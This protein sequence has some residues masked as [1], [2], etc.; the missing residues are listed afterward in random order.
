[1]LSLILFF[2]LFSPSLKAE[3]PNF[4]IIFTDDQGYEDIGCFGSPKIKTPHLDKMAAE[5]RKFTNFYSANSVCSPSRAALMT[6]SYP[7]RVSV[8]GV[9]FP[10]HEIGLNPDEVTIAEVLKEKGYATACIGKWHIGHKPKFLP[11]RQG[12]DSYFGIPY[13]NDMTIDPEASLAD[14][15]NL[16]NGFTKERIKK[17]KPKKNLVPLMRNEEVIEYP[18]DQTTLTKRYTEEA[19]KFISENKD[20]PFFLY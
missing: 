8:P 12:F 6:G 10:R 17:E 1:M 11:T 5:G 4:I 14:N 18:C 16:R 15:I 3:P 2:L 7:T 19:V 20:S 13:S 9:L